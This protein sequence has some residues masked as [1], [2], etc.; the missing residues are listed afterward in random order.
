MKGFKGFESWDETYVHTKHNEKGRTVLEYRMEGEHKEPWTWVRGQGKGRVFYTAWGHDERTWGNPGFHDLIERGIRWATGRDPAMAPVDKPEKPEQFDAPFPVPELT[1]LAKDLKPF[2]YVD[3]GKK[4]P[5]YRP[6]GGQGE[7]L[8]KMQ[9]PVSP[10]ESL[11]HIVVPK[12]FRGE[13]F[14]S[15]TELGSGKPICMNWDERGRLWVAL[16][17]DYPNELRPPEKG[18]DRIVI[19]EDTNGDGKADKVTTFAEKLSIPSSIMFARGGVIVFDAAQTIFLKD[20]NGD[21]Q[22]DTREVLFGTWSMRDTHGGPSNMQYGLDNWNWGMQ[23]Y[24]DSRLTVGGETHRFRQ[25]FFRFRFADLGLRN[26][27]ADKSAIRNPQ[28]EMRL[29]FIRS[30]DNN[31]WGLGMSEEGII[32]GST[33]NRNP[34]V[35]MPIPN[36]YYEAVRGWTPSLML[37]TIADTHRFAPLTDKVRQVDQHGGYTAAA[38]HSLY[39]ARNYPKEYWN[40]TA[41]VAEPTGHLVGTFVLRREGSHFRSNNPFNLMASDDEWT[42]PVMAEVGPDG[43]VWVIDWYNYIVQH[44]PTPTGFTTGRGAAYESDLRD[45][46]H[47]RIYRIVYE[48]NEGGKDKKATFTLAGATPQKL[49]ETLKNDN[50]FWRRHAQRLLVERGKPDV[51]PSL[52]EMARDPGVDEIGLNVGVIHA[53]WAMHGLG[54]LDGSNADATA[55]AIKALKHKSAGVRRNAV[56]VLPRDAKSVAALLEAGLLQDADAQVRLLALLALADQPGT[57]AAGEALVAVLSEARN[58]DDRWIPDA[59]TS[60]AAKNSE[61]FLR[62]LSTKKEPSA[63]LL[64]VTAV[65]AE[66]YARGGPVDS[67]GVVIT[68]LLDADPQVTDA[69]VRGLAK[70]WPA[71]KAPKLEERL[72]QDLERL[73]NRLSPE[74]RGVVVRLAT[75]WGS[76]KFENYSAEATRALLARVKDED[77]KPEDRVAAARELLGHGAREKEMVQPV[78]EL[79]TPRTPPELA[80]GLL[81]ALKSSDAREAGP[82]LLERLPGLTPSVR[83]AGLS[84]LLSR[85]EWTKALLES[86]DKGQVQLADLS[87]DQK[88]ALAAHPDRAIRDKAQELL[89]RGGA[90]PNADRQKVLEELLPITKDKGD[91]AAGKLLFKNQCA[92]CHVHSGEGTQIGPDLSGMAVH[93]KEHLLAEIIDPSRSVEANF[94]L[95]TVSTTKGRLFVGVLAAESK[96][97]IEL[98]DAEGKKQAIL[99]AD[100]DKL[101]VS[102]KSLMPDGFEKDVSRKELTDLLEFLTQ[103]GKYLP[104]PLDKVATAVS[105]RGMFNSEDARAERLVFDDWKPKTLDGVPFT[106]V[107]PQGDR[108]KNVV[109]LH[110]PQETIPPKMPKS[111]SLACN[112]P[113]KAIHLLSGVSGW[114]HPF[115]EKGS[116]SMIVRLHY[117]DG[118]T[119]DHDLKNGEH[120]ADYIR[121][122]DV[123]GSKFAFDLRGRQIR[124]LAIQPKRQAKIER[125]ELLKGADDTV[126]V[127]MAV[128]VEMVE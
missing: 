119:E 28:S 59:A 100:I 5:N 88:Q 55:V 126:P 29:E 80:I 125:V 23:G 124:Y 116:V 90:L 60:A 105:T 122:V 11:K 18:N 27:P 114:G 63:K 74:R 104:L 33:A 61:R 109:L 43:N 101:Q 6:R 120:F 70:G 78:V 108:V 127:V 25:G 91:A 34:S 79:L 35:Y 112:T 56:Q 69:V 21:D 57:A 1:S 72:E 16:T 19:C 87:L 106:L 82:M 95:Y 14:A 20:T 2:E 41:F 24:N 49:V 66:H 10:E 37:H 38:G 123:P 99:R 58:T 121:R 8:S 13:L 96:T 128:T 110:G 92:K 4:I 62:A 26:D 102:P 12:G 42:A 48:K 115:G 65:V 52:I 111:V 75:A 83:S 54:A 45:K 68:G 117:E 84:L 50:L 7:P 89:K 64:S 86:A 73:V 51:L 30:T 107:D 46:K 98:F 9:L 94:H 71:G 103:R 85:P 53:L 67:A 15:E 40:R 77:L 36:R 32:F 22:A 93:P 3:V 44:N 76:K 47:G 17:V 81:E 118:K 97:T 39:T 113:A 31:T